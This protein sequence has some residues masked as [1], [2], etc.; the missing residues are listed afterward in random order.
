MWFELTIVVGTICKYFCFHVI[1]IISAWNSYLSIIVKIW[2][3]W[4]FSAH[5]A[6][7]VMS[8]CCNV[9]RAFHLCMQWKK[10]AISIILSLPFFL[11]I[12]QVPCQY[13]CFS[14]LSQYMQCTQYMIARCTM[15]SK[16][17]LHHNMADIIS[18]LFYLFKWKTTHL[19]PQ[20]QKLQ[21]H[22]SKM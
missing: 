9:S 4:I 16:N 2:Y 15:C 8:K 5:M 10:L 11:Y 6:S 19:E 1:K 22:V 13:F 17:T 21:I 3:P 12:F 20:G 14:L 7:S 18:L